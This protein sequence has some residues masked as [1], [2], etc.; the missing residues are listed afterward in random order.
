MTLFTTA[1]EEGMAKEQKVLSALFA[2]PLIVACL[3]AI[4]IAV[5][6]A[7]RGCYTCAADPNGGPGASCYDG[8]HPDGWQGRS[9]CIPSDTTRACYVGGDCCVGSG[10]KDD[11]PIIIA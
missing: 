1:S 3:L 11:P 10:C 6:S 4:V 7:R 5:P 2:R 9:G 8:S